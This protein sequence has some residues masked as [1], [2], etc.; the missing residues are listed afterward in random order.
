MMNESWIAFPVGILIA[1]VV[2]S[3]GLG[4]GIF[5]M[6]FFLIVMK[7]RPEVAVLTS[8]LIQTAGMGSG[9]IAFFRQKNVDHKLG[10][11]LLAIAVPGI[12]A[13]A[14][15]AKK[16]DAAYI[17]VI[18]GLIV[19][20]TAFL[21]VSSNQKYDDVGNPR[22]EIRSAYRYSWVIVP[23]SVMSGMLSVSMSEWL[24]PIMRSRLSLRMSSAIGTCIFVAFGT[25]VIGSAVHLIAGGTANVSIVL[26]AT[27]G[28]IIGGQIGP[29][30]T[31]RINERLLKEIFI[32]ILTLVG[33]HLI[34]NSY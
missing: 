13:G 32:F 3:I 10:L 9:T 16:I 22:A 28:V 20:T 1:A 12:T 18:L 5:W 27:P 30:I 11:F 26:Y 29:R 14:H 25:C 17:E 34:Y 24:I 31:K 4:G 2:S 23:A 8:L 33:I 7:L 19:M 15:V 21:F 6:P